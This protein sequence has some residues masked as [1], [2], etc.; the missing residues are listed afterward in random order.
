ML[1]GQLRVIDSQRADRRAH[2]WLSEQ[3]HCRRQ[4]RDKG[5]GSRKKAADARKKA[6]SP[7]LLEVQYKKSLFEL[8]LPPASKIQPNPVSAEHPGAAK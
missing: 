6:A 7:S 1:N 4:S 8:N 3:L 5:E 2:S